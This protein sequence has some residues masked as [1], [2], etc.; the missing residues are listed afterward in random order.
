MF[1]FSQHLSIKTP[2]IERDEYKQEIKT[3]VDNGFIDI[4]ISK[5]KPEKS[6]IDG[7]EYLLY[8]YVGYC[9]S[10]EPMKHSLIDDKYVVKYCVPNKRFIKV[11]LKE[12]EDV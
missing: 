2:H 5:T 11:F 1:Q 10:K 9:Y 3:Y 8:D 6:V 4:A 7:S 12:V